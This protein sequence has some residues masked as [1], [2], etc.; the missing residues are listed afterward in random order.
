MNQGTPMDDL[1]VH[2]AALE[3]VGLIDAPLAAKLRAEAAGALATGTASI[4]PA[5]AAVGAA[6]SFFGPPIT[7]GEFFA[8]LGAAFV[9]GG[10]IAFIANLSLTAHPTEIL[11][12]ALAVSAC[13]TFGLGRILARGDRRRHRAAGVAFLATITLAAGSAAYFVQTDVL[14]N[15]LQDQAPGIVIAGVAVLVAAGLRRVLPAVATQVGLVL[16]LVSLWGAVLAW[17]QS[18]ADPSGF[19]SGGAY[20]TNPTPLPAEPVGLILAATAWWLLLAL[21]LGVLALLEVRHEPGDPAAGRR[22]ATTRFLAGLV[23]VLGAATELTSSGSLGGDEYGRLVAPWMADLALLAIAAVLLERAFRRDSNAFVLPA[24]IGLILAMTDFN[25]SYL[26]QTTYLGLLIEGVI[27][28][29]VG[30]VGSRVRGRLARSGPGPGGS[31][32]GGPGPAGPAP[33]APVDPP[34]AT[35]TS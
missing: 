26:A 1:E 13:A 14:R 20:T 29:A 6:P 7:V 21:G 5:P 12:G 33:N 34:A 15:T 4:Q 16:S 24:A 30:F 9:L 22:A 3:A 23:A 28:L 32:P 31:G 11:G 18:I 17:A 27:L 35:I 2:I 19:G 8:Y 10:W 25:F